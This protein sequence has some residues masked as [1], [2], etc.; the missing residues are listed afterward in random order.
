MCNNHASDASAA[1]YPPRV[2]TYL[3]FRD[4]FWPYQTWF[5]SKAMSEVTEERP[6][7]STPRVLVLG[8]RGSIALNSSRVQA[9]PTPCAL[10]DLT[11]G[12]CV[13]E[14]DPGIGEA[15]P[16]T[17][18]LRLPITAS[19]VRTPP[20]HRRLLWDQFHSV[21]YPPAYS[22]RDFLGAYRTAVGFDFQCLRYCP[23][24]WS[25]YL[26]RALRSRAFASSVHYGSRPAFNLL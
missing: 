24:G 26:L 22:P 14:S 7:G 11:C 2:L 23:C 4:L 1:P 17:T 21:P 13:V 5:L 9:V 16:R 19:V 15:Q 6:S 12:K 3:K 25:M 18:T 10:S 8:F 20:R